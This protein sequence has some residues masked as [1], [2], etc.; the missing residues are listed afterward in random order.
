MNELATFELSVPDISCAH[1]KAVIEEG[2]SRAGIRG[3]V[4]LEGKRVFVEGES[5]DRA[6]EVLEEL[7][8]RVESARRV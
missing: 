4:D 6:I 7:L 8:Y 3:R 2:L 5:P 1:C